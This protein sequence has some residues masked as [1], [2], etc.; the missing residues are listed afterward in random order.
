MVWPAMVA[1]SPGLRLEN[2][3]W[4]TLLALAAKATAMTT[5]PR[6]TIMPPL[7]RPTRPR[8]PCRRVASTSWRPAEPAAKPPRPNATRGA[9]PVWPASTPSTTHAVPTHAGH[10]NRWRRSSP[11]A[12]RHG[13]TGA[14]AMRN[15]SVS[16]TGIVIRLK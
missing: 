11:L 13:S 8:H 1:V 3:A 14:T 4:R 7:A 2:S 9:R 6:C 10:S 5:T 16:P 15:S 12:L